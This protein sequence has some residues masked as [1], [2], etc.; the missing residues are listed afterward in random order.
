M[1]TLPSL[2]N[3]LSFY[4]LCSNWKYYLIIWLC[5]DQVAFKWW[6]LF[7]FSPHP[8]LLCFSSSQL[9]DG[10]VHWPPPNHQHLCLNSSELW[11]LHYPLPSAPFDPGTFATLMPLPCKHGALIKAS[12]LHPV[13]TSHHCWGFQ[14]WCTTLQLHFVPFDPISLT[15]WS[16]PCPNWT[17][18]SFYTFVFDS[19][20]KDS[21][22]MRFFLF[23]LN[24]QH[25]LFSV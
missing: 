15:L 5:H 21:N 23:M 4:I 6:K 19:S 3:D 22:Q 8:F 24:F 7:P 9:P 14:I 16:M 13:R 17:R 25:Q 2:N 11:V 12:L 1:V 18:Q 20:D 10:S